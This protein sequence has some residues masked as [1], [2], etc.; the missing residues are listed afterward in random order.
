[1]PTT[2][3]WY[4]IGWRLF[5]TVI[6]GAVIGI[7]R[8]ERG[9]SAGLRTTILVCLAASVSMI[10]V[11]LLLATAGRSP[12]SFIMLDL[13][14]LPL[15]VL[16]GMGFIGAGAIIRRPRMIQGVTTAAT[17][18][19]VTIIG[20]CL[21]G[22]QIGLGL[23]TLVLAMLVLWALKKVEP[24]IPQDHRALFTIRATANGPTEQQIRETLLA[25]GYKVGTW[26]IAYKGAEGER[27][28]QLRCEVRWRAREDV[29]S[30]PPF[31][32]QMRTQMGVQ[33][34]RWTL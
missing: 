34:V 24:E 18:W 27:T 4:D 16:T 28:L 20:L 25:A 6:A 31:V 15:G 17:L 12:N 23:T 8:A 22:G 30:T 10:Q 21:G 5:L 7:N 2:L 19:L 32:E 29:S 11:N 13:M 3:E 33:F 1:M 14:R 9:R 26:D